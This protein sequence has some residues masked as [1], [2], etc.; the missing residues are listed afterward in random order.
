MKTCIL[1]KV[2]YR[3]PDTD[4]LTWGIV[5]CQNAGLSLLYIPRR[6]A[7]GTHYLA[8]CAENV[9]ERLFEPV[10]GPQFPIEDEDFSAIGGKLV[11]L[12][13]RFREE[14]TAEMLK[15]LL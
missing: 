15:D 9:E 12:G 7:D 2:V 8:L 11:A 10:D 14:Q 13:E 5:L 3:P 6:S 1:R 4:R